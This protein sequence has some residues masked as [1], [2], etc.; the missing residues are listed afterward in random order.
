LQNA[1]QT[2]A[3]QN[4]EAAFK[5]PGVATTE[6]G[7]SGGTTLTQGQNQGTSTTTGSVDPLAG[8]LG[9]LGA[10]LAGPS[11]NGTNNLAAI[12]AKLGLG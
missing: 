7:S 5:T 3:Q 4:A 9:G 11:G 2:Q 1:L 12:L 8:L 6:S 10:G